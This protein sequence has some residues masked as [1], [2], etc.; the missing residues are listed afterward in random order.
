MIEK[1]VKIRSLPI[2]QQQG[3]ECLIKRIGQA[4]WRIGDYFSSVYVLIFSR[5]RHYRSS[6]LQAK[7]EE[8]GVRN[9]S[10]TSR[11]KQESSFVL[12]SQDVL[13]AVTLENDQVGMIANSSVYSLTIKSRYANI[14]ALIDCENDQFLKK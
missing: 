2:N 3:T 6:S 5:F 9:L 13:D 1:N 14:F 12:K 8:R 10:T 11:K 4:V 7:R